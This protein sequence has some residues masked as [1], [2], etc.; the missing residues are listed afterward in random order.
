MISLIPASRASVSAAL[1]KLKVAPL[2]AGFR[3]KPAADRDAILDAV[4]AVQAY[5][6]EHADTIL[7]CEIN[8]LLCCA[9]RAVAADALI[10]RTK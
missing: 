7:E 8:P 4:D 3:G 2:L 6:T 9:T 5:V 1:D 10:R